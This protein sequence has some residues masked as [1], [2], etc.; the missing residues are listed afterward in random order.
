RQTP[1]GAHK[2]AIGTRIVLRPNGPALLP[3]IYCVAAETEAALAGE[4]RIHQSREGEFGRM[5]PVRR[6]GEIVVLNAGVFAGGA[7][8]SVQAAEEDQHASRQRPPFPRRHHAYPLKR[9][10]VIR[11]I[12]FQLLIQGAKWPMKPRFLLSAG[13]FAFASISATAASCES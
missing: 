1:D 3:T 10:K 9:N 5:L 13:L 11:L 8:K 7:L 6:N 2:M 4:R 12:Y